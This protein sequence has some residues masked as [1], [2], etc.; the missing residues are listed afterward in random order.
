MT[1]FKFVTEI[2]LAQCCCLIGLV[3]AGLFTGHIQAAWNISEAWHF[4][5]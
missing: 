2:H 5:G 3:V 4:M 1:E